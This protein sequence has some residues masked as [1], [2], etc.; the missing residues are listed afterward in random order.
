[1]DFLPRLIPYSLSLGFFLSLLHSHDLFMFTFTTH[2][3]LCIYMLM[4]YVLSFMFMSIL[5]YQYTDTGIE[6]CA[7]CVFMSGR[8]SSDIPQSSTRRI[9]SADQGLKI[10]AG[11][12]F[13][14]DEH[15]HH[16][17]INLRNQAARYSSSR[18][19]AGRGWKKFTGCFPPK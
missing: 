5:L 17:I 15:H 4:L 9:T 11:I 14:T 7:H 16:A 19:E 10:T 1:M 12:I 2:D 13:N 18:H 6:S 3:R 8:S